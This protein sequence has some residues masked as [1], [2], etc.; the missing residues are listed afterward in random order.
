MLEHFYE[1][2]V[3]HHRFF[4]ASLEEGLLECEAISLIKWII[5]FRETISDLCPC[6]NRLKAFYESWMRQR[7]FRE[8][9]NEFRVMDE[10]YW[11]CDMTAYILPER[12]HETF[13]I[14]SFISHTE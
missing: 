5:E 3:W 1:F 7:F 12:I 9:R 6:D 4:I 11:P 13:T 10:K 2:P 14:R 8:R